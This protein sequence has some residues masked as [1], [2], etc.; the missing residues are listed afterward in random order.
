MDGT[1]SFGGVNATTLGYGLLYFFCSASML[2][3][4]KLAIYHY[5]APAF[6]CL[7]QYAFCVVA[8]YLLKFLNFVEVDPLSWETVKKYWPVP[9]LFS[10]AIFSNNKILQYANIETFIVVRNTT[11]LFVAILD[12][13]VMGKSLPSKRSLGCFGLIILGAIL[14]AVAEKGLELRSVTWAGIY[15]LVICTEMV[16]VKHIFNSV[17]MTVWGRMLYTN[18]LS[19]PVQP[20][21]IVG[22][23]EYAEYP[24]LILTV[25]ALV[26]IGLSCLG[27]FGISLAGTGFRACVSA[28]TFT[29]VGVVNK[30]LTIAVNYVMWSN[31]TNVF[32]LGALML[33]LAGSTLYKP[34][35][36]RESGS[37]SDRMFLSING[38]CGGVCS[39]NQLQG[40]EGAPAPASDKIKYKEVA[41]TE[42]EVDDS[43]DDVENAKK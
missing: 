36:K 25:Q 13:F 8:V 38:S 35:A 37:F 27:A 24:N 15:L 19:I 30:V 18:L 10:C 26:F 32:G 20:L 43:A 40:E 4:N 22:T 23:M 39:K 3:F 33:C 2:L 28:T 1:K 34:A 17:K 11:P 14:Y 16:F 9:A 6:I 12:F 5:Q 41:L 7:I 42:K 29:L 31:H 21:F